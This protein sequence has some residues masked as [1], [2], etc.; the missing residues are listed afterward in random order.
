MLVIFIPKIKRKEVNKMYF[1]KLDFANCTKY[2]EIANNATIKAAFK[3]LVRENT[4]E[5]HLR[6]INQIIGYLRC[7]CDLKI[8]SH[9]TFNDCIFD[10][11]YMKSEL[12]NRE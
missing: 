7:M 5:N 11:R 10:L 2:S 12:M 9:T 6:T 1:T 3:S 8:I 4:R